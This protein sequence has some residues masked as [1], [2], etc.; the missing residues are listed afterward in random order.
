M[1]VEFWSLQIS[2]FYLHIMFVNAYVLLRIAFETLNSSSVCLYLLQVL[3]L[4]PCASKPCF[5][6]LFCFFY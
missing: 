3:E 1:T 5:L 2:K 4:Q 6:V